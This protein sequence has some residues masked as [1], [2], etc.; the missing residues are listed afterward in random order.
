MTAVAAKPE[1]C[2]LEDA[3]K[4]PPGFYPLD[5]LDKGEVVLTFDDGPHPASRRTCSTCS[6]STT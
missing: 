2:K 6:R 3:H 4:R 1:A 5:K